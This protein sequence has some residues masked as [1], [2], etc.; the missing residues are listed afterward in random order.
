MFVARS[1]PWIWMPTEIDARRAERRLGATLWEDPAA[2]VAVPPTALAT[3]Y[4]EWPPTNKRPLPFLP[5]AHPLFLALA[6]A[7]DP[8]RGHEILEEWDPDATGIRRV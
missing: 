1:L 3:L 5:T 7:R 6:L 2:V 8:A 4:R